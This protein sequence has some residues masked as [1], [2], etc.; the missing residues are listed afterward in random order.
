MW[1]IACCK[2]V[3]D[4]VV[5]PPSPPKEL[6]KN[7]LESNKEK[8]EREAFF[9][10]L[11]MSKKPLLKK[12]KSDPTPVDITKEESIANYIAQESHENC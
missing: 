1:K 10:Q 11:M 2:K 7:L 9:R 3:P 5:T 6:A 4:I 12:P 8:L